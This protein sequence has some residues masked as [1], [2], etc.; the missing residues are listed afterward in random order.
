[1]TETIDYQHYFLSY[2]GTQLPLNLVNPLNTAEVE[3]RNT[4]YG[5]CLNDN[6]LVVLIHKVVYGEVELEHIYHYDDEGKLKQADIR[7]VDS[8]YHSLKF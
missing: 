7:D 1:M 8:E 4:F 3:N 5:A 6:G 2:S